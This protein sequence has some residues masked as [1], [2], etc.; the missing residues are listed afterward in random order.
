MPKKGRNAPRQSAKVNAGARQARKKRAR[1]QHPLP[2][3][4]AANQRAFLVAFAEHGN[5][6]LACEISQVGRT[7]VRDWRAADTDFEARYVA[8][9][10]DAADRLEQ[11]A[12]RRA[13]EGVDRPLIG[14]VDKDEDGIVAYERQYSDRLLITLLQGHRPD[15]FNRQ[16]LEHTGKDGEPL[17][18]LDPS[19]MSDDQLLQLANLIKSLGVGGVS[20]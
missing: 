17:G 3:I 14:R 18:V 11:E 12:R 10:D 13:I 1:T 15:R 2:E 16:R 20:K 6:R 7:T 9:R 19:K 4:T 8:A 5:I